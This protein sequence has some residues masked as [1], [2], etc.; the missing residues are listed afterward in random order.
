VNRP[1]PAPSFAVLL[2]RF[3]TEH[4][5]QHRAVSPRTIVAYRDTFRLLLAFAE[6]A[7]GREPQHFLLADLNAKFILAF[8]D[9]LET[10]RKNSVRSRNARLAALRSFLKYAAHHDLSEPA[11]R[12]HLH[13]R[14]R[15][16]SCLEDRCWNHDHV[17]GG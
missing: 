15:Q 16:Q 2:Q 9:Y 11:G 13:L 6:K 10:E 1:V 5:Q 12:D 3:F 7:L 8:L 4:L 14:R 17:P